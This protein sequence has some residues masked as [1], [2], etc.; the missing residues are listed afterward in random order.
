MQISR[1]SLL[2]IAAREVI[3]VGSCPLGP[4]P[5][6]QVVSLGHP[7]DPESVA[8]I[9]LPSAILVQHAKSDGQPESHRTFEL[10]EQ[11]QSADALV[12]KFGKE[13]QCIEKEVIRCVLDADRSDANPVGV[14]DSERR[15]AQ[16]LLEPH[17]LLAFVPL[18]E[19]AGDHL[20]VRGVVQRTEE[21]VVGDL[22]TTRVDQSPVLALH[23]GSKMLSSSED[24]HHTLARPA[25][26]GDPP[27]MAANDRTDQDLSA[28]VGILTKTELLAQL[29]DNLLR[30][31]ANACRPRTLEAGEVLFQEG[32]PSGFVLIVAAGLLD[33]FKRN[34]SGEPIW[35]RSLGPGDV[36]GL[37]SMALG[38]TRSA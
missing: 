27:R 35:L 28:Q 23:R 6:H 25:E 11:N 37:T 33:A 1:P 12:L 5:L 22:G 24:P 38:R 36:V 20:S 17:V 8:L 15:F 29:P 3:K 7:L 14:D 13:L 4:R 34:D 9:Q 2:C 26:C 31:I 19:L 30:E 16:A 32:D 10:C 21:G 18:S